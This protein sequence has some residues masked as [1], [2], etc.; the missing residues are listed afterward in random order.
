DAGLYRASFVIA[1]AGR[2]PVRVTSLVVPAY[3]GELSRLRLEAR[4]GLRRDMLGSF[5]DPGRR[6]AIYAMPA[7]RG[8]A[9]LSPVDRSGWSY[10][11]PSLRRRLATITR[12]RGLVESVT[13]AMRGAP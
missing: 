5:S 2:S 3:G 11:G 7:D 13:C 12:G 8:P 9:R 1:P 6:A 4:D 10:E